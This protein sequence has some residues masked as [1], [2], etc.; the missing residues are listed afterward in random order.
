MKVDAIHA[1]AV[2]DG[3]EPGPRTR[4]QVPSLDE[5]S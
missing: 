3:P 2:Y 4:I 1:D 5:L